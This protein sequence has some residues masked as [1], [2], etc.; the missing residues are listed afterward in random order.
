MNQLVYDEA[1]SEYKLPAN[2]IVWNIID[3]GEGTRLIRSGDDPYQYNE[4]IYNDIKTNVDQ[5][6]ARLVS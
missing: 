6:V 2:V 5:F 1:S 3:A 4:A